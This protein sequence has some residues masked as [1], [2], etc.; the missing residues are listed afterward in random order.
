MVRCPPSPFETR[1]ALLR[2]RAG[3][4]NQVRLLSKRRR[5]L[6]LRVLH[7]L[8]AGL[9]HDQ[10]KSIVRL[11]EIGLALDFLPAFPPH[12]DHA[13]LGQERILDEGIELLSWPVMPAHRA[14][15]DARKRAYV[16]GIH[17]FCTLEQRRGC[18]RNS[19]LP[20]FRTIDRRKLGK[21]TLRDKPG[22]DAQCVISVNMLFWKILVT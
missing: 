14:S 22:H 5:S 16:A 7:D 13:D 3:F 15:K 10:R 17:V 12:L 1:L 4:A 8:H 21:S 6:P 11:I 20:E 2:V 18:Q 9:R 19:G